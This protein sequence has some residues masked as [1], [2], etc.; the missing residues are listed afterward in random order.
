MIATAIR[1]A[2]AAG[3]GGMAGPVQTERDGDDYEEA[4]F[5]VP[6]PVGEEKSA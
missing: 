1:I 5:H 4:V 3:L 6:I 2:A